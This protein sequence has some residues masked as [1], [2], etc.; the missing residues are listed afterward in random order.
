M[1]ALAPALQAFFTVRLAAQRN[2]SPTVAA[3]RDLS[4]CCS[5]TCETTG[6]PPAKLSLRTSTPRSSVPSWTTSRSGVACSQ[7]SQ[8]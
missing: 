7:D 2:A 4:A 8:Q 1:T 6:I 5:A 3:Y